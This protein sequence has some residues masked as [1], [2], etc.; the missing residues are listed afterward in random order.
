M[1]HHEFPMVIMSHRDFPLESGNYRQRGTHTKK[2]LPY[3]A[4]RELRG[5]TILGQ[6][7][8]PTITAQ[9]AK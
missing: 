8:D 1:V 4:E 9:R 7:E 5:A 6:P 2:P 3:K